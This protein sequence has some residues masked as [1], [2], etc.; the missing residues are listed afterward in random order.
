MKTSLNI[1]SETSDMFSLCAFR[2]VYHINQLQQLIFPSL[3]K[4]G[5]IESILHLT[6]RRGVN[7]LKLY[8]KH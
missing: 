6:A 2:A 7:A 4:L 8:N 1:S 5:S 3:D